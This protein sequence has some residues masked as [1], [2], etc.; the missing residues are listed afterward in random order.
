M[1][2]GDGIGAH[3]NFPDEEPNDFSTVDQF[4]M[5]CIALQSCTEV[6]EAVNYA[7]VSGL[8]LSSYLE[9]LKFGANR[10]LLLLKVRHS[11]AQL[12]QSD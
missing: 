4:E 8:V 5:L 3:Q 11:L 2:N 7:Q 9:G 12:L 1:P 10:V 6:V